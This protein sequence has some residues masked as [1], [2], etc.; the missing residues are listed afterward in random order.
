MFLL[1][2][3]HHE[4]IVEGPLRPELCETVV[5]RIHIKPADH[6]RMQR[7]LLKQSRLRAY[8]KATILPTVLKS[9][10]SVCVVVLS[11]VTTQKPPLLQDGMVV[12]LVDSTEILKLL[13]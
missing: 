12:V 3:S 6:L 2:E 13:R 11:V 7:H 10:A 9:I 4:S 1:P 5:E 8:P